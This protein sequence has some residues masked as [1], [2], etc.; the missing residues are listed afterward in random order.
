MRWA[1]EHRFR[2]VPDDEAQGTGSS[3]ESF[4]KRSP[5]LSLSRA[6]IASIRYSEIAFAKRYV[7]LSGASASRKKIIP[8][9]NE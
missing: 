3:M 7:V 9:F 4:L 2:S 5:S 8:A 6:Y 1:R